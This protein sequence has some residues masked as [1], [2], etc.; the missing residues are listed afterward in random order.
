MRSAVTTLVAVT[1]VGAGVM[2][3]VYFAFS[4]FVMQGLRQLPPR[5][6][7]MAMQTINTAAP[8]GWL[9]LPLM[10]T[11]LASVVLTIQAVVSRES[12]WIWLFVGAVLYLASFVLTVAYHVPHNDALGRVDAD[13]AGA[14]Q[15]WADYVGGWVRWNHVRAL[16]CVAATG[17][18]VT[19]L[20]S[21]AGA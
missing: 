15:T 1:A 17:A 3:G 6:A 13:A 10:G 12:G 5:E 20:V 8:K 19:G 14:A 16:T 9:M 7:I 18:F 21:R 4:S 11:A 2:A